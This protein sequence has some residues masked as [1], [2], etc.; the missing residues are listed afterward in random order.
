MYSLLSLER[1][2]LNPGTIQLGTN[3]CKVLYMFLYYISLQPKLYAHNLQTYMTLHYADLGDVQQGK[4][5][6]GKASL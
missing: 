6:P 4:P 1:D 2:I 3:W 5:L